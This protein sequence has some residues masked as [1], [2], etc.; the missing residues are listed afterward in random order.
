MR[1]AQKHKNL[2]DQCDELL[3]IRPS[4]AAITAI[5]I[6]IALAAAALIIR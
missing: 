5:A 6:V 4:G 1:T 2:F 3:D